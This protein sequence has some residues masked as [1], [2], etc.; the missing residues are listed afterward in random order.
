MWFHRNIFDHDLPYTCVV[1]DSKK[2]T[3]YRFWQENILE[4]LRLENVSGVENS[5][6]RKDTWTDIRTFML[7]HHI[8]T[9]RYC[10]KDFCSR[11]QNVTLAHHINTCRYCGKDFCGRDL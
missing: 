9:C 1:V 2:S 3:L 5:L 4:I 11:T 7:A 6:F 8:N 10:G